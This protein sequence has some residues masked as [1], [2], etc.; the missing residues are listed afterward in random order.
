[1]IRQYI[2][3]NYIEILNKVKAVTRNH[4]DTEDLLQD[5]I[6]NLL[7]KG[8]DYTNQIVEDDKVQ[9]YIVRMVHIQFNS[10]TSPF[11]TQY[12]K[13]SLKSKEIDEELIESLEDKQEVIEDSAK[14]VDDVKLYI[15]NLPIYNRTIAEQHFINGKSQREMSKFYNINRIHIAKDLNTIKKNIKITFNRD[16]YGT[17]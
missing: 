6:L 14:L 17:Y 8:S 2:E 15:G 3:K 13:S 12:K 1:M 4:Q 9:H 11:Y 16:E 5:C 7:E 10:S